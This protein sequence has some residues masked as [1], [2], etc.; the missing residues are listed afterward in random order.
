M[1][2]VW[3]YLLPFLLLITTPATAQKTEIS[4]ILTEQFFDTVLD[5]LFASGAP[6]E[7]SIARNQVSGD[8]GEATGQFDPRS[9]ENMSV[10]QGFG[11]S[12][13][14]NFGEACRE[15]IRLRRAS[16]GVATAV[17]FRDGKILAPLA[18][19]GNYNPPLVGC[20]DFA[21]WAESTIDLEFDQPGQRLVAKARVSNVS[22][23]GT[24]GIGGSVIARLV[25]G[26]IDR[27][28]NPIE[29]IRLD[30]VSFLLP[31]Q[32]SAS[33]RMKA[34]G[35]RH[36]IQNGAMVVHIAYEFTRE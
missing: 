26:S 27:K 14:L 3:L 7:F 29:I 2:R 13:G 8:P 36:E 33:V 28:I 23:N 18:F 22:L 35:V 21:G 30:K 9:L 12:Y 17:R 19:D 25:Q 20:V 5:A 10:D 1:K 6:L 15:A 32:N 11:S 4:I 16:G 34:V 31:V 24:G